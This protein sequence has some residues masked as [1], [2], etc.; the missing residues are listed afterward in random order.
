MKKITH[1][2]LSH[3]TIVGNMPRRMEALVCTI[4]THGTDPDTVWHFN[5][6]DLDRREEF[7]DRIAGCLDS[8]RAAS[9]WILLRCKEWDALGSD[10]WNWRRTFFIL[11]RSRCSG[12]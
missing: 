8:G 9:Y 4:L 7:G 2:A 12:S 10:V 6:T 1:P 11:L 5:A 3:A